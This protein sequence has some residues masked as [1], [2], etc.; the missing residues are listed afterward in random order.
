ME[1]LS[2]GVQNVGLVVFSAIGL[3]LAIYLAYY[4]SHPQRF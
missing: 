4:M 1:F 2:V 3:G